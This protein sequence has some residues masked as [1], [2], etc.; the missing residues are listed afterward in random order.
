MS[1]PMHV[2][3]SG[4][5]HRATGLGVK[6]AVIDSGIN[7]YHSHVRPVAGG[8][9][10]TCDNRGAIAFGDDYRDCH[11][12]G[13]AV[14]GI[15]RSKAPGVQLYGVK[16][17]HENLRTKSRILAAAIRSCVANNVRVVNMSLGTS[18]I[19][20]L[21]E[22][23]EACEAATRRNMILVAAGGEEQVFP[24]Y[25]PCVLSARADYRYAW[26]GYGYTGTRRIEFSAHAWPRPLPGLRQKDNLHGHSMAAAHITGLVGRIIEVYPLADVDL[27]RNVLT[28][29]CV[30]R[31]S[32]SY[33]PVRPA[34]L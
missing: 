19:S 34:S 29:E 30:R 31:V 26:E 4:A 32:A 20:G 14:A 11:G 21:D 1:A 15:I 18:Q 10:I 3:K 6:V 25:F 33:H 7:T 28:E 22:L 17:L 5:I 12:H 2:N 9:S 8:V 16:V 13:T 27:V 23:R 24:A